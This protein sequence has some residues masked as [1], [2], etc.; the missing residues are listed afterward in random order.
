ME[1]F[2]NYLHIKLSDLFANNFDL[3]NKLFDKFVSVFDKVVD[4]IAPKTNATRKEKSSSSNP[5]L[6]LP[7]L[8]GSNFS[9]V[10]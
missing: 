9:H 1:E 10:R 4:L 2:L 8:K 3:A 6:Q 5:G 7:C